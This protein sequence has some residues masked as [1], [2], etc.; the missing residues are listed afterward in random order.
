MYIN[1]TQHFAD[2]MS[3]EVFEALANKLFLSEKLFSSEIAN[4]LA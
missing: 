4:L 3:L 1:L 2:W